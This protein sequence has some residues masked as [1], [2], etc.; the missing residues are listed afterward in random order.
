MIG[1]DRT[2]TYFI[3]LDGTMYRGNQVIPEAISFIRLLQE[4]HISYVF[5]TN[6]AMRTAK[7]NVAHMRV[8]GFPDIQEKDFF[9]SAMAAVSYMK[10]HS[11]AKY[12]YAIGED[13]LNEAIEQGG[14][15]IDERRAQL[16]FVGLSRH[17][18][19]QLYSKAARILRE[20]HAL[21]VGTNQD[22]R[23][24]DH[25]S[26]LIGNGAILEMLKYAS[27]AESITI[28]KPNVYMMEEVLAYVN[29]QAADCIVI[30]D[31][32]ETDIAFAKDN[33]LRSIMVCSGVHSEKDAL[34]FRVRSDAIV[35]SLS[36]LYIK[37]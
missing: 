24:P 3:D 34:Q 37:K 31:N 19:Y 2:K 9:T 10:K 15:R 29:K 26:F 21:L 17:A 16:V 1:I 11:S 20:N 35:S 14:Y 22:R 13:G 4:H 12:V 25:D 5:V 30:G 6:N 32:L 33:G 23:I 28:G 36:Q 7:Q 27:E 8:M 18:D